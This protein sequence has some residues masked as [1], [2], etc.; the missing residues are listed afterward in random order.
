MEGEGQRKRDGGRLIN[1][2][3]ANN[4]LIYKKIQ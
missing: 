2:L 1:E 4:I 3:F